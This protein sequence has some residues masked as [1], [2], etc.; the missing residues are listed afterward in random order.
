MEPLRYT[1]S[2]T[3]INNVSKSFPPIISPTTKVKDFKRTAVIATKMI[4]TH[5]VNK[6]ILNTK[7]PLDNL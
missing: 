2:E 5:V 4:Y 6:P 3:A 7:T 1:K